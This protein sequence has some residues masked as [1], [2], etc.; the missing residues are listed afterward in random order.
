MTN[1]QMRRLLHGLQWYFTGDRRLTAGDLTAHLETRSTLEEHRPTMYADEA[2]LLTEIDQ[3]I[4]R[5]MDEIKA[6]LPKLPDPYMLRWW[7][8]SHW[9]WTGEVPGG[10][11]G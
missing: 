3:A 7:G 11:L 1:E 10:I 2:A 8:E 9:W 5:R 4:A 6:A